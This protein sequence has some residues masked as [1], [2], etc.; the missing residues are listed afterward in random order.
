M[1]KMALSTFETIFVSPPR[2]VPLYLY[3]QFYTKLALLKNFDNNS[4]INRFSFY[5]CA[6][7][8][9]QHDTFL[10]LKTDTPTTPLQKT[11]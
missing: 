6:P 8:R 9:L 7:F 2:E 1:C 11:F 3:L 10:S 4:G 5:K